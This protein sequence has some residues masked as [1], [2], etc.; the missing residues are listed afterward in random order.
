MHRTCQTVR[1]MTNITSGGSVRA[2]NAP[3]PGRTRACQRLGFATLSRSTSA[4]V[5]ALAMLRASLFR[6]GMFIRSI[7]VDREVRAARG[8]TKSAA[9]ASSHF[10]AFDG[11]ALEIGR[12]IGGVE[13]LAVEEGLL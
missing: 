9:G 1:I 12:R 4:G 3:S 5:A 8:C 11:E 2:A 10:E 13:D 7:S 6:T